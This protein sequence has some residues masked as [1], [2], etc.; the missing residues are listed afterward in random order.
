MRSS[1]LRVLVA[2]AAAVVVSLPARADPTIAHG[3]DCVAALK[4]RAE[5]LAERLR[6][7]DTSAEAPLLPIVRASFAFIG[8]A[9]KQ[10]LRNPKADEMMD[11]AEKAQAQIPPAELARLQDACQAE[12][13][14]LLAQASVFEQLF[15]NHAVQKRIDRLRKKS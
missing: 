3:A 15:V 13:T 9:Y 1:S 6:Q 5:P 2:A 10:G 12:G 8:N 14:Q 11:A 7:G 4:V